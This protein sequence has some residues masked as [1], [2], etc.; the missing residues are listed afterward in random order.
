MNTNKK[1]KVKIIITIVSILVLIII[2][3]VCYY[4]FENRNDNNKASTGDTVTYTDGNYS[5]VL[6][7]SGTNDY[8][9]SKMVAI[10]NMTVNNNT[11]S[12]LQYII[13]L[14]F[15]DVNSY[16]NILN[17]TNLNGMTVSSYDVSKLNI[18]LIKDVTTELS[19]SDFINTEELSNYYCNSSNN[20][21]EEP[22]EDDI[23]YKCNKDNNVA[24]VTVDS[25]DSVTTMYFGTKKVYTDVTLYNEEKASSQNNL[26]D[27]IKYIYNDNEYSIES[28]KYTIFNGGNPT[29]TNMKNSF[30]NGYTCSLN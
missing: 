28:L 29:F 10:Y 18:E 5:C 24:Y 30:L 3:I 11:I 6:S 17:S 14:T 7:T 2:S 16:T 1:N 4:Y 21:I 26:T 25:N 15:S 8:N 19:Y 20:T 9:A 23:E 27:S 22:A 12:N 13:N